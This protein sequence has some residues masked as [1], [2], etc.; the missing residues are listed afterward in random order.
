MEESHGEE[1]RRIY[2][3]SSFDAL[4]YLAKFLLV[5]FPLLYRVADFPRHPPSSGCSRG[6]AVARDVPMT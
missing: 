1:D 3:T 2:N 4:Y 5:H 6:P